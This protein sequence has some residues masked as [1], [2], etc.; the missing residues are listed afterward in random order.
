MKKFTL[1]LLLI[2]GT[3]SALFAQ[4]SV[5]EDIF[6]FLKREGYV[7][8]FDEDRDILFKVQ[9]INYY[10]II[11]EVADMDYAYVEVSASLMTNCWRFPTIRTGTNSFASV[12]RS[13]TERTTASRSPW[14]SSQTTGRIPNTRWRTPCVSY[15]AGSRSSRRN[16]TKSSAK[17]PTGNRSAPGTEFRPETK[18]PHFTVRDFLCQQA[19]YFSSTSALPVI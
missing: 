6:A 4:Q 15:P 10:A 14:N 18:I 7:P 1:T 5:R 2:F 19:G 12:R 3:V 11:K 17:H 13:E 9:G 16:S 8:T